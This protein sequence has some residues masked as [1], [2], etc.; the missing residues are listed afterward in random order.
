MK[1]QTKFGL[2][3]IIVFAILAASIAAVSFIWVDQNTIREAQDRVQ[4]H[5]QAS[6]EIFNG[7]LD[8]MQAAL[9]I[10]AQDD[11]VTVFLQNPQNEIL[12]LNAR[13]Y[14][15]SVR[16]SQNMDILN[17]MNGE[18][19]VLLRTRAPYHAGELATDDPVVRRAMAARK[20]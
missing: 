16:Q 18:G 11:Q 12:A 2:G 3:I 8:R 4:L 1:L 9:E 19:R 14:L 7:K 13:A 6:W 15:E 10:L 17:L 5:I 20:W